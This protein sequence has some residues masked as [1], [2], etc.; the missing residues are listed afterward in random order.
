MTT[1]GSIE[2]IVS[3]T[4]SATIT[5]TIGTFVGTTFD[6]NGISKPATVVANYATTMVAGTSMEIV[7]VAVQ[8]RMKNNMSHSEYRREIVS[9]PNLHA[10]ARPRGYVACLNI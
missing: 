2:Q 6:T 7:N 8:R 10:R 4:L 9:I 5:T 3:A 1:S